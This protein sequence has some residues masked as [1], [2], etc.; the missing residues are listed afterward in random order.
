M[1]YGDINTGDVILFSS[2]IPSNFIVKFFSSSEWSHIGIAVRIS[3][4]NQ[5]NSNI[6]STLYIL[7]INTKTNYDP[8]LKERDGGLFFNKASNIFPFYPKIYVRKLKNKY[9][10]SKF[11]DSVIIFANKY[12][13]NKFPKNPISILSA[14]LGI[15]FGKNKCDEMICSEFVANFYIDCLSNSLNKKITMKELLGENSP[16]TSDICK[17]EHFSAALCKNSTYFESKN[18]VLIKNE[19][20]MIYIIIVPLILTIAVVIFIC[21]TIPNK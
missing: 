15:S 3:N 7:E 14:W 17:P 21:M 8:I 5:I 9:R 12:K 19:D 4:D 20:D 13:K 18:E 6:D 11:I 1:T 10:T 2:N 16:S